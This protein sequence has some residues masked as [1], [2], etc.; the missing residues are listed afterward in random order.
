[1]EA[2]LVKEEKAAEVAEGD[3]EAFTFQAERFTPPQ[4]SSLTTDSP[5]QF[6]PLL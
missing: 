2:E 6:D 5:T 3:F 1:M 4:Q